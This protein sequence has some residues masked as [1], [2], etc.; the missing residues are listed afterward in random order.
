MEMKNELISKNSKSYH[1]AHYHVPH[2]IK[3]QLWLCGFSH[4]ML[5]RQCFWC[6]V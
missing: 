2:T 4:G 6:G 5:H 3:P 1:C